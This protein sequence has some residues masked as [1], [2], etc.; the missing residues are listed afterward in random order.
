M[1]PTS[2]ARIVSFVPSWTETLLAADLHV[3]GRTRFCI[4]PEDQVKDIPIVGGTKDVKWD[5]VRALKPD[6]ILLDREENT[7]EMAEDSP[8][9]TLI[10]DVRST[11]D[12]AR[13]LGVMGEALGSRALTELAKRWRVQTDINARAIDTHASD[14]DTIDAHAIDAHAIDA[15]TIHAKGNYAQA[16]DADRI[17]GF[18]DWVHPPQKK[19]DRVVYLIWK[20]P[21]MT[22]AGHTF[23]GSMLQHVGLGAWHER[24]LE[25]VAD[26][27]RYPQIDIDRL[28]DTTLLLYSSEPYPFSKKRATLP[29]RPGALIDGEL[30]SWFGTR[31]LAYLESES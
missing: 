27:S 25:G 17:P 7:R 29:N 15:D 5:K 24:G 2:S 6:W 19:I 22:V 10:T 12:C 1:N 13:D 9:P 16:V 20:D 31:S 23:I 30:Y 26:D 14:V 18:L 3:V 11:A 4:H 8:F 21:W 28:P